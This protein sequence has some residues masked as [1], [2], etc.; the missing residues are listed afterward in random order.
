MASDRPKTLAQINQR[1]RQFWAKE[2]ELMQRRIADKTLFNLAETERQSEVLR[3][4]PVKSQKS[5]A[6]ALADAETAR[7]IIQSSFSRKGG[8]AAKSDALQELILEVVL[9]YPKITVVKLL[10]ELT[11]R[12]GDGIVDRIEEKCETVAGEGRRI[13]F[14]QGHDGAQKTASVSGLKDRLSRAKKKIA[15]R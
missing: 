1:N 12:L 4:V 13:H 8:T 7:K 2:S 6:Q 15:S 10:R 14:F 3:Q 11:K 5:T 9:E